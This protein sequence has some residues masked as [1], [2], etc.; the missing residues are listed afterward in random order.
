[1]TESDV[2]EFDP[3]A[4][5]R[6][7]NSHGVR[8]VVIGGIA[9]GVQGAI[10]VTT[11][12]DICHARDRENHDRL[13]L[14]LKE[15]RGRPRELPVEVRV[16][17]DARGLAAGT[18]WTLITRYGRLDLIG[19]PGGGQNYDTLVRRARLIHGDVDYLVASLDDL[20]AMKSDA[21]RPKDIGQVELLRIAAEELRSA[22]QGS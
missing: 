2:E 20:I 18:N 15:I 14:A 9:A 5:L 3:A 22:G 7:L 16:V 8:F 12:L 6:A 21:A 4:M 17:L 1:V 19:E 11:D 13:A 10:W